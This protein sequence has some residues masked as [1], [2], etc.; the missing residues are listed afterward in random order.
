MPLE[1][2]QMLCNAI[3]YIDSSAYVPYKTVHVNHPCSKWTKASRQNWL[4]LYDFAIKLCQEYT[5]RYEKISETQRALEM[6]S[7]PGIPD[8][9]L[10][11]F[12]ICMKEYPILDT[13]VASYR[14]YYIGDK[15]GFAQWTK[16]DVPSWY[17][18]AFP[19]RPVSTL[20]RNKR[21]VSYI[22]FK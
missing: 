11:P 7:C 5:Y 10:T 14:N 18:D 1:A 8:T 2:T 19:N 15:H 9:G 3:K 21:L 4:W 6:L 13:P 12:A 22:N 16:R 20:I 17:R